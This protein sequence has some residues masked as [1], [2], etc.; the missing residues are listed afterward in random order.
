M[1]LRHIIMISILAVLPV[2]SGCSSG[3]DAAGSGLSGY[4]DISSAVPFDMTGGTAAVDTPKLQYLGSQDLTGTAAYE[5]Y[6]KNFALSSDDT[7]G[8]VIEWE[9]VSSDNLANRLTERISSDMSP[10]LCDKISNSLPYLTK[11]NVYEDL[12]EYI[13]ITAPQWVPY[14]EYITGSGAGGRYFYPTSVTVSP[15]VLLY[16]KSAFLNYNTG[17]PLTLWQNSEWT[18]SALRQTLGANSLIGGSAIAEN[19]LAS[20]GISLFSVDKKGKVTS[21]LHSESFADSA[22][23]IAEYAADRQIGLKNGIE[24]LQSGEYLYLSINSSELSAIRRDYPDIDFETVPF[25]R[26]DNA[27]EYYYYAQAEGYLVPKHAKNI[28]GAASFINYSR[29]ADSTDDTADNACLSEN[30]I[31]T[32]SALRSIDLSQAVF[33]TNYCLDNEANSA[34]AAIFA[35]MYSNGGDRN[36]LDEFIRTIEAPVLKSIS[37]ING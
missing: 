24:A 26:G 3:T 6:I 19:I 2:I 15:Y 36:S 34:A 37:E 22:A 20:L 31:S 30:D 32:L 33:D 35:E 10:D 27:D 28:K 25:P 29:I 5:L 7:G 21:N 13:D 14:A 4:S 16:R 18:M 17:D 23:F 11:R 12:T 9:R 1:K 8:A